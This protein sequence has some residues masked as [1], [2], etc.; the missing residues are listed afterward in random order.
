[1]VRSQRATGSDEPKSL[2]SVTTPRDQ[3]SYVHH[4]PSFLE[5]PKDQTDWEVDKGARKIGPAYLHGGSET[6]SFIGGIDLVPRRLS[7]P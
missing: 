5:S 4:S 7:S 2:D 6:S 1:M 3:V